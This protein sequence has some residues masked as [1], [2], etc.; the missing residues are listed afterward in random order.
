M[1]SRAAKD[2]L[3]EE[4]SALGKAFSSPRRLELIDLLAQGPRSVDQLAQASGLSVANVSQ[5]L[6][7]LHASGVVSRR[8]QGARVHYSLAG[9]DV[10]TL[11]LVLR[12]T[13]AGQLAGVERAAAE[14]LGEPVEAI[15]SE[16]LCSKLAHGEVTLV[17]VRPAEEFGAGHI[18]GAHSIPLEELERRIAEL[19]PGREVI[20]YCRGPLCAYAHEAVRVLRGAGYPARRLEEGVPEWRRSEAARDLEKMA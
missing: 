4:I 13:A 10:L 6:Q 1:G 19:P 14:Y 18:E 9:D 3:F 16:E 8:R 20:A 15:D 12:D 11:W 5:H 2:K 17:D 7:G